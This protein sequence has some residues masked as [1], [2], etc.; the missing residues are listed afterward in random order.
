MN[1]K[2]ISNILLILGLLGSIIIIH[3]LGHFFCCKI[4]NIQT[5]TFSI[6]F[7]PALIQKQ[8]GDT[9]FQIA[10]LPLG[11]YVSMNVEQLEQAPYWQKMIIILAGVANNFLLAFLIL[12][13]L[14]MRNRIPCKPIVKRVNS[15]SPAAMA[16]FLP[17]DYITHVQGNSLH[18]SDNLFSLIQQNPEKNVIFTVN[19][20]GI[21]QELSATITTQQA[22]GTTTYGF[23][24]IEFEQDR[25]HT[26]SLFSLLNKAGILWKTMIGQTLRIF[27][28]PGKSADRITSTATFSQPAIMSYNL[29][30]KINIL[31]LFTAGINIE[32]GIFNL[33][34][35][36]LLDGG[37]LVYYTA[38]EIARH[39]MPAHQS[40]ITNMLYIVIGVLFILLI[41]RGRQVSNPKNS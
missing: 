27:F 19:R 21:S 37:Q 18:N 34:P 25:M 1:I 5:P 8:I 7:G 16:G 6:G 24:G 39:V 3:E 14:A 17:G 31:C 29:Q 28:Q 12:L 26:L 11:G 9:T 32:L 13:F 22:T 36:P 40:I 23:L 10:A 35:I 33:F 2:K 15:G 20:Q 30:N 41:N 38:Q 4:F